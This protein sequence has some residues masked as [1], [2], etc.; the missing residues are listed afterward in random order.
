MLSTGRAATI[1]GFAPHSPLGPH[2]HYPAA[3]LGAV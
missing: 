3:M 2:D 1:S